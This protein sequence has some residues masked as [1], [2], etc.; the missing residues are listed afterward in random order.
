MTI[1]LRTLLLA[2]ALAGLLSG[3][4]ETIFESPPGA[5][6]ATCDKRWVG[7]WEVHMVDRKAESDDKLELR[8]GAECKTLII[9]ENG[10][11]QHDLDHAVMVFAS[12]KNNSIAALKLE[13]STKGANTS[14]WDSGY[15][16]FSYDAGDNEIRVRQPDDARVAKLLIEGKLF[17]RTEN[18]TRYPGAKQPADGATL[19]NFV[20]GTPQ[21]MAH[22]LEAYP[23]FSDK[24]AFILKRMTVQSMRPVPGHGDPGAK[25]APDPK[26]P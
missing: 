13:S 11:T 23:L 9:V 12:I 3:C 15:H 17:G 16:Y 8:V 6:A 19:H 14:D 18:I 2:P 5:A 24:S 25:H 10:T 21:E 1:S 26:R 20:A 7:N 22:A 4:V